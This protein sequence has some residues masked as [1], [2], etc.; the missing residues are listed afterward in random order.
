MDGICDVQYVV[1]FTKDPWF[2]AEVG[3]K[4]PAPSRRQ[5]YHDQQAQNRVNVEASV[6]AD[7]GGAIEAPDQ[8]QMARAGADPVSLGTIVGRIDG[9]PGQSKGRGLALWRLSMRLDQVG[10]WHCSVCD[11]MRGRR[12]GKTD[13]ES[14]SLSKAAFLVSTE[15]YILV[16]ADTDTSTGE[17]YKRGQMMRGTH[18][19]AGTQNSMVERL[20]CAS[21]SGRLGQ[22]PET[23]RVL[24]GISDLCQ[25]LAAT[26]PLSML[27][28]QAAVLHRLLAKCGEAGLSIDGI[29][30]LQGADQGL[31]TLVDRAQFVYYANIDPEVWC[32]EHAAA[33]RSLPQV[34]L[35]SATQPP[36]SDSGNVGDSLPILSA[37]VCPP[38]EG[39]SSLNGGESNPSIL[40]EKFQ[41]FGLVQ[42]A[43]DLPR[44]Q[45]AAALGGDRNR[46]ALTP[47]QVE[48]AHGAA[49][50][51]YQGVIRTVNQLQLQQ[52]L[53]IGFTQFKLRAEG[54][55]DMQVP[56]LEAMPC[57]GA[58]APWLPLVQAILGSDA[59]RIH[60][61]VM[62]SLPGSAVQNWHSDGD[63]LSETVL[64]PPHCLNVF[65]PL[66]D[67]EEILGPTELLPA[68]HLD[69]AGAGPAVK[70][71]PRAGECLL[72]DYRL[73]HRGLAN[74]SQ[75]G[76]LRPMVYITYA[77]PFYS[78]T[79]N[80]SKTRYEKL[81]PLVPAPRARATRGR[82]R[83]PAALD[84]ARET[85]LVDLEHGEEEQ[86][87]EEQGK[88]EAG[89]EEGQQE[90]MEQQI[91]ETEGEQQQDVEKSNG[92][93][94]EGR[95][96]GGDEQGGRGTVDG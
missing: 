86:G 10:H 54:R 6:P 69:W 33:T 47:V 12:G 76:I 24:S 20:D 42:P 19:V 35:A 39:D 88:K 48:Q 75:K 25:G 58:E 94:Q 2:G 7:S 13:Q 64:H 84:D 49:V 59:K 51:W 67:M 17:E 44:R 77:K 63:H 66:V 36:P 22:Q 28:S 38:W 79:A 1:G 61:G 18:K 3:C 85:S 93:E 29:G 91:A 32:D 34:A 60:L 5:D 90:Q 87:Q 37:P 96:I 31:S 55:Y 16:G 45:R 9:K 82:E 52:E 40:A 23:M 30:A 62:L 21:L 73:K 50:E 14:M 57:F 68:S 65:V 56:E 70:P 15:S 80:F 43:P 4:L 72:F 27:G 53:A 83:D 11:S 89:E 41:R 46:F 71:C 81:P 92:D 8:N 26:H 78:D 95:G 74:R